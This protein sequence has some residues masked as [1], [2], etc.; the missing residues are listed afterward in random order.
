MNSFNASDEI[1]TVLSAVLIVFVTLKLTDEIDWSWWWVLT[2]M[3]L[4]VVAFIAAFVAVVIA[5]VVE[6]AVRGGE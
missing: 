3:W 2:P 1:R 5:S 4:P 6:R